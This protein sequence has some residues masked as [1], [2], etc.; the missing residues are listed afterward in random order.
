MVTVRW[1]VKCFLSEGMSTIRHLVLLLFRWSDDVLSVD[2]FLWLRIKKG[3]FRWREPGE[4]QAVS[5]AVQGQAACR[6]Q[7]SNVGRVESFRREM[8]D[9]GRTL[10]FAVAWIWVDAGAVKWFVECDFKWRALVYWW[11]TRIRYAPP[12]PLWTRF[13]LRLSR[14]LSH[15]QRTRQNGFIVHFILFCTSVT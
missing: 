12:S 14:D 6:A 8:S 13:F 7:V 15:L 5:Q 1:F 4:L 11:L 2:A 10:S 9:E 3:C